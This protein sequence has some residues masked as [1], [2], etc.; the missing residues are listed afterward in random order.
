MINDVTPDI[1]RRRTWPNDYGGGKDD[2]GV[3]CPKCN[4][5]RTSVQY[6]RHRSGGANLRRR[7][8]EHCGHT[9]PTHERAL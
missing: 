1:G 5:A 4:C 8:C 2:R 3:R 9:F 7:Q 6:M